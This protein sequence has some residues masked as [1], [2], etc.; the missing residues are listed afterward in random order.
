[1]SLNHQG[2]TMQAEKLCNQE[3][4]I[5]IEAELW[6]MHEQKDHGWGS[7]IS[8]DAAASIPENYTSRTLLA[9]L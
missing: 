9:H 4:L 7:G 6:M 1:M 8:V 5:Q 2:I 3:Y